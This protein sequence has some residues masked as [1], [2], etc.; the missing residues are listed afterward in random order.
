MISPFIEA[1]SCRLIDFAATFSVYLLFKK[2]FSLFADGERNYFQLCLKLNAAAAQPPLLWPF[3]DIKF[4][5]RQQKWRR[6]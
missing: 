3:A 1:I 4:G 2:Q 5:H 6:N